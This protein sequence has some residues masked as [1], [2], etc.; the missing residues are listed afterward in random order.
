VIMPPSFPVAFS[1][2]QH[3]A[4]LPAPQTSFYFFP[5]SRPSSHL[6]FDSPF[7]PAVLALSELVPFSALRFF[8]SHF[9]MLMPFPVLLFVL[10]YSS[11]PYSLNEVSFPHPS[12]TPSYI[13]PISSPRHPRDWPNTS[14]PFPPRISHSP[15]K[16][17]PGPRTT[18]PPAPPLPRFPRS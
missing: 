1:L 14:S 6:L 17:A 9:L 10:S 2:P 13:C 3:A 16:I 15:V 11:P 18:P 8:L 7:S 5:R 4:T 12:T